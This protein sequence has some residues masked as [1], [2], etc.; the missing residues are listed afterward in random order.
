MVDVFLL[1]VNV[2]QH[3]VRVVLGSCRENDY[4]K[5][6]RHVLKELDA[7]RSQLE[8]LLFGDEVDQSLVQIEDQSVFLQLSRR[9]Q[10]LWRLRLVRAE[11]VLLRRQH[12][13]F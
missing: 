9:R 8:L 3:K 13:L 12:Y 5:V 1:L 4:F 2:V 10:V 11:A 7:T 6:L